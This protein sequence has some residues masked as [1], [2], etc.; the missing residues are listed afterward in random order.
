M[1]LLDA[2][3][4]ITAKNQYYPFQRIP[5]FWEWLVHLGT[6]GAVKV[7]V[8]ILEEVVGG[9]DDLAGWLADSENFDALRLDEEV[10]PAH[11]QTV[12][13]QYASDLNDAELIKVGRDPFLIAYAMVAPEVRVVVTVEAS[14]PSC[15]R[16]NRRIPD[17]CNDLGVRWCNCF[18]MLANLNF[19]TSWKSRLGV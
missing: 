3:V 1:H 5:E 14:K 9:A 17:V 10:D 18:Q 2:N 8:E 16:A 11:I 19:S 13:S 6:T 4:L 12:I 15:L 7:P